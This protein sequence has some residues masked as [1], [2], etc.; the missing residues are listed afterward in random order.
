MREKY[1]SNLRSNPEMAALG[2]P[3]SLYDPIKLRKEPKE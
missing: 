1:Q 2:N 3:L